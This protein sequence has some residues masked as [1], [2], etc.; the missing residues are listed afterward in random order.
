MYHLRKHIDLFHALRYSM[1]YTVALCSVVLIS[2]SPLFAQRIPSD[3]LNHI[4]KQLPNHYWRFGASAGLGLSAHNVALGIYD[5]SPDC[6][7]FADQVSGMSFA[8]LFIETPVL[9]SLPLSFTAGFSVQDRSIEFAETYQNLSRNLDGTFQTVTTQQRLNAQLTGYGPFA[10]LVWKPAEILDVGVVPGLIFLRSGDVRQF[11]QIVSPLGATFTETGDFE[12]PVNRGT[13]LAFTSTLVDFSTW[14]RADLPVGKH[15]EIMPEIGGNFVLT[16]FAESTP[17]K[18]STFYFSLGVAWKLGAEVSPAQTDSNPIVALAEADP[19]Q[20][21]TPADTNASV[22]NNNL[23]QTPK[24][25]IDDTTS[26]G[27][28]DVPGFWVDINAVGIDA[29]NNEYPDP[30]I[31]ISEAPWSQ[32]IP[33]LPYIFF[34]AESTEIPSRYH[35]FAKPDIAKEF[36]TDSL[37]G[38]T[39]LS[40]HYHLLNILGQRL[41]S[42]PEVAM[43]IVGTTSFDEGETI[44]DRKRL[45]EARGESV[46]RYLHQVWGIDP[47]RINVVGG[48]PSNP[49]SEETAEGR[50]ENRRAE[51]LFDG[52]SLTR[53]VVVERLARIASPPAIKFNL[54]LFSTDTASIQV[55]DWKITVRQGEK[56]LLM[57]DGENNDSLTLSR[58]YWSLGDMRVNRDLTPVV[59][60]LEVTDV[61]GTVVS[62]S[63]SFQVREQVTRLPE[64]GPSA[65]LDIKEYVLVGFTYNSAQLSTGHIADIYE[66]ARIGDAEAWVEVAGYTDRVGDVAHNRGLASERARNVA[67]TLRGIRSRLSM[68]AISI[69]A[70]RGIGEVGEG[71]F[72]NNLPEGRIF[73]RMVRVT[74]NRRSP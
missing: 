54:D 52:E 67:D 72:D 53:P 46:R 42:R 2:A 69:S 24:E 14:L 49:S 34:D 38:Q 68:P 47:Q 70:V 55:A 44:E 51:F 17:W 45:A 59:Y 29:D 1:L 21:V 8:R 58:P 6:G 22:A 64:S 3:S 40:L 35:T 65:N 71:L 15:I 43:T 9:S 7:A 60:Q 33:L 23:D 48:A 74:V 27:V 28:E 61:H 73:S 5:N 4:S 63:D 25:D 32:S 39:P 26:A 12:R 11:E 36:N 56:L 37:V 62:A 66:I 50:A 18:S 31:E 10:G 19:V 16:S 13:P 41:R 57:L 20:D 30:V